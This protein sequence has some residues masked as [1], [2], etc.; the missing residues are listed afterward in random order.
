MKKR[1]IFYALLALGL[2][3]LVYYRI[4]QNKK[5]AEGGAGGKGAAGAK[6]GPG[7]GGGATVD[8]VIARRQDF[9]NQL[10]VTGTIDANESV[11]LQSE[12]PGLITKINF[13]EGSV[14]KKGSLLVQINNR[15]ILAQLQEALTKQ[16]LSATN[17]NRAKQLLAKGAISQEEYD[18]SLAD[19]R[20]LQAQTQLIRTQLARTSI[21]APFNGRVG[22]RNVSVGGY[23]TPGTVIANLVNTD[24]VKVTFS[25]PEKYAGRIRT[26]STV[27]FHTDASEKKHTG[28][29]FAIEPGINAQTRT[30]QIRARA[31]NPGNTLLPGSF[32]RIQITLERIPGAILVPTEAIVPVMKG[33]VVFLKKGGKAVETPVETGTRTAASILVTKG[34]APGDTVLTTGMMSIKDGAP[35]K[36]NIA[37]EA[38]SPGK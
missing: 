20:S 14:V 10:E 38:Q 34:I 4:G 17:E 31:A 22:L 12:V 24:P 1:Y 3:Y 6:G 2:A 26:G 9:N 11:Q 15:D 35:V 30:L 36:V 37:K 18:T 25:V 33:K 19:L 32:A 13:Q 5:Q 27:S 23:L 21:Y 8:G 28:T 7:A 16:K 29:V